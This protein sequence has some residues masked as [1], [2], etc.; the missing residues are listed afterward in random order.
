MFSKIMT[1]YP[2]LPLSE[3]GTGSRVGSTYDSRVRG[4]GFKPGPATYFREIFC[5][6]IFSLPL[7]REGHLSVTG[8]SMGTEYW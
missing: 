7:I 4:N 5:T 6:V 2:I 1:L 3:A 8:K